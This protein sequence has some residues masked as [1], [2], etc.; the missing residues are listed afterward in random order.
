MVEKCEI[1]REY[2]F[3]MELRNMAFEVY[4]ETILGCDRERFQDI[5]VE[6]I[7]ASKLMVDQ[8]SGFAQLCLYITRNGTVEAHD[9]RIFGVDSIISLDDLG[10]DCIRTRFGFFICVLRHAIACM[11]SDF[12]LREGNIEDALLANR[13]A[14]GLRRIIEIAAYDE[15]GNTT[16]RLPLIEVYSQLGLPEPLEFILKD[17]TEDRTV[18]RN[19]IQ[20]S[21]I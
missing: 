4:T 16:R 8:R 6:A 5:L 13:V 19:E 20:P 2:D 7:K 15:V 21:L 18:L 11:W 9:H 10:N 1:G 14:N 3:Q 12:M 17:R